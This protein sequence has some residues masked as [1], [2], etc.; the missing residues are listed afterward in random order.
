MRTL[1]LIA[2]LLAGAAFAVTSTTNRTEV[3]GSGTPP[4]HVPKSNAGGSDAEWHSSGISPDDEDGDVEEG[5]GSDIEGSGHVET[6]VKAPTTA[7]PKTSSTQRNTV[8]TSS[9]PSVVIEEHHEPEVVVQDDDMKITEEVSTRR[10]NVDY[11]PVVVPT[12]PVPDDR[13]VNSKT[14]GAGRATFDPVLKPGI[15]AAV[16]GGAVVGLLAA[17]LMVMFIIYRMR[18][19]DEGSYALDEPKQPPHYSYA[20]QKAPTKEFYA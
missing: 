2:C 14:K 9:E 18:K 13:D 6:V 19:K 8:P 20:Y 16:I 7:P 15:L 3:E 10:P 4:S 17:I 11:P 12:S 5:S 1:L